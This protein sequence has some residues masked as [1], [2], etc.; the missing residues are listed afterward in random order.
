MAYTLFCTDEQVITR[1]GGEEEARKLGNVPLG[2]AVN[3]T[4]CPQLLASREDATA[5]TQ[6]ALG[7]RWHVFYANDQAKLVIVRTCA[8]L[9]VGYFWKACAGGQALPE[10]LRDEVAAAK[11]KLQQFK[12]PDQLFG[13]NP[14]P[15]SRIAA[16]IDNSDGGR[17]M[18]YTTCRRGGFLG[19]RGGIGRPR[20]F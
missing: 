20:G 18:V 19:G 15:P 6:S 17:R 10:H 12:Q 9:A 3:S 11:E 5:D 13:G 1:L 16:S 7:S 8:W 14:D 4:S 2:T